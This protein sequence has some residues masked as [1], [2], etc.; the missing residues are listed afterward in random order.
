MHLQK[1]LIA[2]D[3][4]LF[5]KINHQSNIDCGKTSAR[6]WRELVPI[7]QFHQSPLGGLDLQRELE[8]IS[9][10][11]TEKNNLAFVRIKCFISNRIKGKFLK[12]W[13]KL[14]KISLVRVFYA[15]VVFIENSEFYLKSLKKA[16]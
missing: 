14:R 1:D 16:Q 2:N 6:L 15:N 10:H 4:S 13:P 11:S 7:N 12:R 9:S 8:I 5:S 3:Q